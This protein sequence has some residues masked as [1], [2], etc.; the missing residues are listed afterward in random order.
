MLPLIYCSGSTFLFYF[1]TL[2]QTQFQA[3]TLA[4]VSK[5][6]PLFSFYLLLEI[7]CSLQTQDLRKCVKGEE[8]DASK[9]NVFYHFLSARL[10]AVQRADP[11]RY[12]MSAIAFGQLVTQLGRL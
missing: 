12:A 8:V 1:F 9:G 2:F 11:L 10:V 7:P 6:T 4:I 3:V 5:A